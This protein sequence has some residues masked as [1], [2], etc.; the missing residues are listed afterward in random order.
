MKINIEIIKHILI[1]I[2]IYILDFLYFIIS[3]LMLQFLFN[4]FSKI[5]KSCNYLLNIKKISRLISKNRQ[6]KLINQTNSKLFNSNLLNKKYSLLWKII[7]NI[8]L[9]LYNISLYN[10]FKLD[11]NRRSHYQKWFTSLKNKNKERNNN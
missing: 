10:L 2:L 11:K 7:S 4:P 9:S 8:M 5:R 3:D 6:N 1:Y